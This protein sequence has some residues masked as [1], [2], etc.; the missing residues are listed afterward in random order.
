VHETAYPRA[1]RRTEPHYPMRDFARGRD[2]GVDGPDKLIEDVVTGVVALLTTDGDRRSD[3]LNAGQALQRILLRASAEDVF[4]A[5]HTQALEV[6][7]LREFIRMRFCDDAYP[8]MLLRLGRAP[9]GGDPAGERTSVR[10]P[11]DVIAEEP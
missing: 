1:P 8:Q 3:W 9:T 4:S 7:E 6:S 5:F 11:A 10:R 2:W